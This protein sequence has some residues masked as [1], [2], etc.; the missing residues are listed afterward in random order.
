MALQNRPLKSKKNGKGAAIVEVALLIPVLA[1]LFCGMLE[2]SWMF[3]KAS[4]VS[5]AARIGARQAVLPAVTSDQAV[6]DLVE[7]M[8]AET[9]ITADLAEISVSNVGGKTGDL[10]NVDIRVTYTKPGPGANGL[11]LLGLV[12]IPKPAELHASVT[13]AK[14]GPPVASGS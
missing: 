3:W 14:E 6:I 8:L 5:Q 1:W 13:M 4:N 11:E 10:V 12:F 9:G 2:Y 7:A